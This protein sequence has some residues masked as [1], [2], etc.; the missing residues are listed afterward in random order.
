MAVCARCTGLYVGA[1]VAGP[2]ALLA[3]AS[4]ASARARVVLVLAALPTAITWGLEFAGVAPF[5]NA[6]RFILAL[7][8]GFVGAW[9]VLGLLAH[10]PRANH[11]D[12]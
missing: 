5:S 11:E 3:A 6:I 12:H 8:L 2:L 9:L 7:P 10:G 4:V 1:A